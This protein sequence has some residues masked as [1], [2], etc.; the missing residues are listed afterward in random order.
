MS[1]PTSSDAIP[2]ATDTAEPP[3]EP[4]A[5]RDPSHELLVRPWMSLKVCQSPKC[6]DTLVFP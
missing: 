4:P 2:V 1:L 6:F 5:L 3:D